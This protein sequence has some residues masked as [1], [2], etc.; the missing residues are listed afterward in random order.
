MLAG[1]GV[2]VLLSSVM[3]IDAIS[4]VVCT[5][6][7]L[8]L[9][10]DYSLLIVSRF[11]EELAEGRD[12]LR[13]G[14]AQPAP[15]PGRTTLFAGATLLAALALSAFVQPGSLLLSLATTVG[16]A[17]VLSVLVAVAGLPGLL[18]LLGERVN[19]GSIG[20]SAAKPAGS[21]PG[22][23]RPPPGRCAARP[24]PPS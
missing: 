17:T 12:S 14:A 6:M 5:M 21:A 4:L 2:L 23:R 24:S 1:R 16:V 20:R 18:A 3:T 11:R 13:G 19:A 7:G 10:V 15:P 8:A 22:S 9:G